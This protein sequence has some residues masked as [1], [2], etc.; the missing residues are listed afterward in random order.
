MIKSYKEKNKLDAKDNK[1][2]YWE[3]P[4]FFSNGYA[5]RKAI[6]G[7]GIYVEGFKE[8][9]WKCF[10]IDGK[11]AFERPFIRGRII[12]KFIAYD[13]LGNVYHEVIYIK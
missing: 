2:G 9:L 10:A 12:G 6:L 4:G 8:G 7:R 3:E 11:L 5:I 13:L 1:V